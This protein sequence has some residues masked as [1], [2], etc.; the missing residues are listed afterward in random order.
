MSRCNTQGGISAQSMCHPHLIITG[1][2]GVI[3]L[4]T[5]FGEALQ[6]KNKTP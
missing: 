1:A 6:K 3:I 4:S 5:V 2:E